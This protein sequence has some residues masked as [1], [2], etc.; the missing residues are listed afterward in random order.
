MDRKNRNSGESAYIPLT[1]L[2]ANS[3]RRYAIYLKQY[4]VQQ[5]GSKE[6]GIANVI[7][8]YICVKKKLVW[9]EV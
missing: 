8:T 9:V 5:S 7:V 4:N 6:C 1:V 2:S 3:R